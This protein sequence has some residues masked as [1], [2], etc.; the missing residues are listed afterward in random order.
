MILNSLILYFRIVT[1][2]YQSMYIKKELLFKEK[3]LKKISF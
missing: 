1:S 3:E 2:I